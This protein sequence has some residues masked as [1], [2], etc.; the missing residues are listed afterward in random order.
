MRR[1]CFLLSFFILF[2]CF[3]SGAEARKLALLIGVDEYVNIQ[4]LKCCVNDMKLLKEALKLEPEESEPVKRI[5]PIDFKQYDLRWAGKLYST[6]GDRSQ[7]IKTS[8][9][10]PTAMADIVAA[11]KDPSVT[12][13]DLAEKALEWG[14]RTYSKGTAWSFF[15]HAAAEYGFGYYEKSARLD[16]LQSCLDA[17]GWAVANMGKGYWTKG[18][19]YICV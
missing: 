14:D 13:P 15:A 3:T 17:G 6:H 18:G 1:Y 9:C 19:H 12:P 11:V 4:S 7:T 10:G 16:R 5:K 2:F 8:G